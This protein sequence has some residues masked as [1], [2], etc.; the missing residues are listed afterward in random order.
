MGRGVAKEDLI[1]KLVENDA[2]RRAIFMV[3]GTPKVVARIPTPLVKTKH[4]AFRLL[5]VLFSDY[6]AIV[7][8]VIVTQ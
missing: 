8:I 5:N 3:G 7:S 4:C 2:S 1:Q 6:F